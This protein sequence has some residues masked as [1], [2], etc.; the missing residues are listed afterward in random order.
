MT[1]NHKFLILFSCFVLT[2][3]VNTHKDMFVAKV[4]VESL[5]KMLTNQTCHNKAIFIFDPA[6]PTCM[7]YLQNEYSVMQDKFLDSVDY[8]FIS[9]STISLEKYR[10]FFHTIG[11][12]TGYLFSLQESNLDFL[13]GNEKIDILKTIKYLFPNKEDINIIGYP[14]SAMANKENRLKLEYYMM[15]DSSVI[16]RPQPW[17][18]L[19][20]SNLNEIDFYAIDS[21]NQ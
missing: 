13:Q 1:V 8:V 3:C 11:I 5:K 14:I 2:A 16:I 7:F 4:S 21:I 19:Y 6:C 18:K 12:K 15:K 20:L 9:A 17:H 10:D